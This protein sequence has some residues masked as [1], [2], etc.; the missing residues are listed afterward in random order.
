MSTGP[1]STGVDTI[2]AAGPN[3]TAILPDCT[4][5]PALV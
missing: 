3:A 4:T 1:N 2:R 5:G